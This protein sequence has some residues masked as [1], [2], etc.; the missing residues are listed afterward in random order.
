MKTVFFPFTAIARRQAEQMS[1]VWGPLT[2]LQPSSETCS[3]EMRALCE[4][5]RIETMA[6]DEDPSQ[7]LSEVMKAFEQWAAQHTGGD[8]SALVERG[9]AVPFFS[10]QSSTQIVAELRKRG[11]APEIEAPPEEGLPN[12]LRARLF[13][14]MAERF[15]RQQEELAQAIETLAEKERRMMA[16]LKGEDA[17]APDP[18]TASRKTSAA[19]RDSRLIHPRLKAWARVMAA[20][21]TM[22]TGTA[23]P[24]DEILFLTDSRAALE[25]IQ[26]RFP[27]AQRRLREHLLT[28]GTLAPAVSAM[29]PPWLA[30]RLIRSDQESS[31]AAASPL[32]IEL[33]E[34]P[35]LSR[36]AFFHRLAHDRQAPVDALLP[37]AIQGSCWVG[38]MRRPDGVSRS[39]GH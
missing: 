19:G 34:I 13:L 20:L 38:C 26:E 5:G 25:Q 29:L 24:A 36:T 14:A 3:A 15:D 33:W 35:G 2:L 22:S 18:A 17:A 30:E 23:G 16:M 39:A 28:A 21:E 31:G 8:L 12:L 11:R 10:S 7:P 9:Q 27:E 32:C 6:P 37:G 1:A 4:E